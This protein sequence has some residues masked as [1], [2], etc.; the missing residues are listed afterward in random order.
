M[1]PTR[2]T[3]LWLFLLSA[4]ISSYAK[5]DPY[6]LLGKI[7]QEVSKGSLN[8]KKEEKYAKQLRQLIVEDFGKTYPFVIRELQIKITDNI[9]QQHPLITDAEYEEAR[10]S[11]G[12][13][14]VFKGHESA[15]DVLIREA[16]ALSTS[17]GLMLEQLYQYSVKHDPRILNFFKEMAQEGLHR[18]Q[19]N[20]GRILLNGWGVKEDIPEG[21]KHL[22]RAAH[23]NIVEAC[24]ELAGYYL[25]QENMVECEKYLR[26]GADLE[27]PQAT[28]NLAIFEQNRGNYEKTI[29][30]L[31]KVLELDP[32]YDNARFELAR[33]YVEGW[34]V[35][36]DAA[37]GFALIKQIA[38]E[39]EDVEIRSLAYL[40]LSIL[41]EKGIGTQQSQDKAEEYL[42]KSQDCVPE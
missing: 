13:A 27:S 42:K 19:F 3:L 16:K 8:R 20:Y 32:C 22:D 38:E 31:G 4:N 15:V 10:Y 1:E 5:N 34:G 23:G 29:V 7:S 37:K 17:A 28:Y 39:S 35:T 12:V 33:M 26:L 40:N 21:L 6:K 18:G 11:V 14:L 2:Y 24:L 36:K 9:R 30:L 41:S 25:E